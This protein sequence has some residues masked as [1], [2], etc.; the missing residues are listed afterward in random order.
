MGDRFD[1]Y[2]AQLEKEQANHK[3][4]IAEADEQFKELKNALGRFRQGAVLDLTFSWIGEQGWLTLA[5]ECLG[6]TPAK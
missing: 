3:R 4:A 1:N 2:K 5:E 6:L